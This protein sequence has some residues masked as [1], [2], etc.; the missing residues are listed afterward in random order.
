MLRRFCQPVD[1]GTADDALDVVRR[2]V[3]D[4]FGHLLA[5]VAEDHGIDVHMRSK[6]A[7]K[8][9]TEARQNIDDPAR[10]VRSMQDFGKTNRTERLRFR[11]EYYTAVATD[12]RWR[13]ILIRARA[14][15]CFPA[16]VL[17]LT[18]VGSSTEKLKWDELTGLTTELNTC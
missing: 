12:N 15:R 5:A 4:F 2:R 10:H 3:L 6:V 7:A 16:Q 18:P 13:N 14:S 17:R 8:F 1:I 11:R 9:R